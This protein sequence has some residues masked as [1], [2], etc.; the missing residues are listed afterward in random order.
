MTLQYPVTVTLEVSTLLSTYCTLLARAALLRIQRAESDAYWSS[1]CGRAR[2]N[3]MYCGEQDAVGDRLDRMIS[4]AESHEAAAAAIGAAIS[5]AGFPLPKVIHHDLTLSGL[6][7]HVIHNE[8]HLAEI[9]AELREIVNDGLLP[10]RPTK[11]P[12]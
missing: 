3:A 7:D 10:V 12:R 1:E 5:A 8:A 4:Q 6:L 9:R 2:S 11:F